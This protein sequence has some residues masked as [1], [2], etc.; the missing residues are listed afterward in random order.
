M[1][2]KWILFF[3]L[4]FVV[5]V[6]GMPAPAH[7]QTITDPT[8]VIH[9]SPCVEAYCVNLEYIGPT[10][11]FNGPSFFDPS[12]DCLNP[13]PPP[14]FS[15]LPPIGYPYLFELATPI[16]V[17]VFDLGLFNCSAVD[18]PGIAL[19]DFSFGPGTVTFSGCNYYGILTNDQ[20][21]TWNSNGPV[22]ESQ[23]SPDLPNIEV[24]P[25]PN[26]FTLFTLGLALVGLAGFARKRLGAG[27]SA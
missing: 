2:M 3:C 13:T 26:S 20:T 22:S 4:L 17:P 1:K 25:E 14:L 16:T 6:V 19:P 5:G 7:A 12:G 21:F 10:T 23:L 8:Y 27:I 18:L 9:G 15:S 11:C 24:V